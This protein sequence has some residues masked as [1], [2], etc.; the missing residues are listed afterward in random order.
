MRQDLFHN[1]TVVNA[2]NTQALSSD[3]TTAG[4]EIDLADYQGESATFVMKTGAVSAGDVTLLI[5]ES[6]VSGSGFANV[7]DDDLLGTEAGTTLDAA[8]KVAKIGYSGH[9]RYLKASVVTDNSANLTVGVEFVA[10]HL[11][12]C[13]DSTQVRYD[14]L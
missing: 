4:V 12:V 3:T 8:N 6:D 14:K 5:Q 9:K 7:A 10:G 1:I 2:L 11:G 13:P